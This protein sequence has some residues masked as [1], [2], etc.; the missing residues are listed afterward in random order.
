MA[1]RHTGHQPAKFGPC[2]VRGSKLMFH[3]A[4]VE[5]VR[6]LPLPGEGG[7]MPG[8]IRKLYSCVRGGR[9]HFLLA[10]GDV[11]THTGQSIDHVTLAGRFGAFHVV[12]GSLETDIFENVQVFDLATGHRVAQNVAGPA[13]PS[14]LTALVLDEAG[15]AA[16][17]ESSTIEPQT[18]EHKPAGQPPGPSAVLWGS[19]ATHAAAILDTGT[20]GPASVTVSATTVSWTNAGTPRQAD[21]GGP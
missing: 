3:D 12:T 14:V 15:T 8:T 6:G 20:I 16:W 5:V 13:Y 21:L 17:T 19:S 10:I 18:N 11:D 4:R 2:H 9:A 1:A 7:P